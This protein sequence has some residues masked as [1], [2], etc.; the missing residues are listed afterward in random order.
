[1]RKGQSFWVPVERYKQAWSAIHWWSKKYGVKLY[2]AKEINP[3]TGKVQYRI[4]KL[5]D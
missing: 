4:W 3:E 2:M 5:G 1:M